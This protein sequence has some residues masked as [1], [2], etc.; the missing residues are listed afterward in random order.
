MRGIARFAVQP[1]LSYVEETGYEAPCIAC[2]EPTK[3]TT[4]RDDGRNWPNLLGGKLGI[5]FTDRDLVLCPPGEPWWTRAGA[6]PG[7]AMCQWC[8]TAIVRWFGRGEPN[9][10]P[11]PSGFPKMLWT[12]LDPHVQEEV[13]SEWPR[14]VKGVKETPQE[15]KQRK[16]ELARGMVSELIGCSPDDTHE[17]ERRQREQADALGVNPAQSPRQPLLFADGTVVKLPV[18]IDGLL[19]MADLSNRDE[20]FGV[21]CA[22]A[23]KATCWTNNQYY[24]LSVPV[25]Y[26]GHWAWPAL[27]VDRAQGANLSRVVW[28][29][30]DDLRALA[31]DAALVVPDETRTLPRDRVFLSKFF[32]SSP[33]WQGLSP[34][35]GRDLVLSV[36]TTAPGQSAEKEQSE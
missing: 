19:A 6:H 5:T 8:T 35:Q 21:L 2:G 16:E 1:N 28:L 12:A 31:D 30:S 23:W 3:Y 13:R 29:H 4:R 9:G 34:D 10:L 27:W 22:S 17:M 7:A 24:W 15:R 32:Q 26:G 11:K 33:T 25:A 18:G 36:L 14:D 20:P